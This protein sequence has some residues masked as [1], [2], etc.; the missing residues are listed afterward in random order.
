MNSKDLYN[1]KEA[2]SSIYE[3]YGKEKN[4]KGEKEEKDC[5][6]KEDKGK[7]NCAKKVCH[8]QFGEG[9]CIFGEHAAPDENG[10]VNFYDV[11]FEHG[12]EK[13]VPLSELEVL[14]LVEHPSEGHR[15]EGEKLTEEMIVEE[16]GS[17]VYDL[18]EGYL[19]SEGATEEEVAY[20]VQNNMEELIDEGILGAALKVGS[21]L[22]KGGK[23]LKGAKSALSGAKSAKS[24]VKLGKLG[25]GNVTTAGANLAPKI[26]SRAAQLQTRYGIGAERSMTSAKRKIID[27]ARTNLKAAERQQELG[28]AS[29]AYV[30]KA[31]SAL[32]KYLKAGYSKYGASST[33]TWGRGN[34][35]RRRAEEL[36]DK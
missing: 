6:D 28:N 19:M 33:N 4:G 29:Q 7:H 13:D 27:K 32:D 31:K 34:K 3:G 23:L 15:Y 36:K 16:M 26:G 35:A 30:D 1:L 2:Y 18:L 21:K 11:L 25:S 9:T 10:V 17:H 20:I 5:V 14:V 8:E 22:L 24:T 12:V